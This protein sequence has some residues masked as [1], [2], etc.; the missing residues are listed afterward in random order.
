[1]SA[2]VSPWP[3]NVATACECE[4]LLGGDAQ[5]H[6]HVAH[7]LP[8]HVGRCRFRER[9]REHESR[10]VAKEN[11]PHGAARHPTCAHRTNARQGARRAARRRVRGC[12]VPAAAATAA[13]SATP[14]T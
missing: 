4:G 14:R 10:R 6:A 1:M 11:A 3:F 2:V 12:A 5:P 7:R 13:L 9:R 8:Q